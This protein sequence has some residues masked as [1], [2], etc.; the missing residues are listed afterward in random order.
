[1]GKRVFWVGAARLLKPENCLVN[2]RLQHRGRGR[3]PQATPACLKRRSSSAP[4]RCGENA[5]VT[6]KLETSATADEI[7]AF[8]RERLAH[9]KVPRTVIFGPL[10]KASTGKIQKFA[11]RERARKQRVILGGARG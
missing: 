5:F 8:C 4:T 2:V 7:I 10:P 3:P 1:V 9:F 11:L 6:L